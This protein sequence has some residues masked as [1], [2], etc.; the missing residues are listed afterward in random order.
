MAHDYGNKS[1][2]SRFGT[3][4]PGSIPSVAEVPASADGTGVEPQGLFATF[5]DDSAEEA[6][7]PYAFDGAVAS[8]LSLGLPVLWCH[9]KMSVPNGFVSR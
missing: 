9:D 1:L 5:H 2:K 7:L 4:V 6:F 8:A 3:L